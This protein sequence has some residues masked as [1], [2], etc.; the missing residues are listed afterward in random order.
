MVNKGSY[1]GKRQTPFISSVCPVGPVQRN[2]KLS[3]PFVAIVVEVTMVLNLCCSAAKSL[4]QYLPTAASLN[5]SRNSQWGITGLHGVD[6]VE[7]NVP[8]SYWSLAKES[9]N[10]GLFAIGIRSSRAA[11]NY[12]QRLLNYH[13]NTLSGLRPHNSRKCWRE[14]CIFIGIITLSVQ[15]FFYPQP[16]ATI[17]S[18]WIRIARNTFALVLVTVFLLI[19]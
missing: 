1:F 5:C 19:C 12:L 13:A 9:A 3:N 4:Y 17:T 6:K 16:A 18:M 8:D 2:M 15:P 7:W 14:I 10:N 11:S